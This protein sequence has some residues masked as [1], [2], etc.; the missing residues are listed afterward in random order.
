M[1]KAKVAI[2]YYLIYGAGYLF[3]IIELNHLFLRC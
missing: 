2:H 3:I 1:K